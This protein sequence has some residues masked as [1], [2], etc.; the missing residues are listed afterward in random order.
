MDLAQ[1][2][3]RARIRASGR[4]TFAEFMALAL[5]GPGGYYTQGQ[6][7]GAAGDYYTSPK[8]H[9]AF[10]ALI[11]LQIEQMWRLL[12]SPATFHVAEAG[13]GDGTLATDIVGFASHLDPG[14]REALA[15]VA[16]DA[17][18]RPGAPLDPDPPP[19]LPPTPS[20]TGQGE[21]SPPRSA[22]LAPETKE[23]V[24]IV[25]TDRL[26]SVRWLKTA[27]FPLRDLIGCILSNEL[28]DAL[29]VHRVAVHGG[30]LV[31][32]YV[33][34]QGGSFTEVWDEP[35]TTRLAERLAG[36]RAELTGQGEGCPARNARPAPKTE[37]WEGEVALTAAAWMGAAAHSLRRGYALTIDYGDESDRLYTMERAKGTLTSYYRHAQQTNLYARPGRQDITAHANFT[38]LI[39]SGL[40]EGLRPVSL[41]TQGEFLRNLGIEAFLDHAAAAAAQGRADLTGLRGLIRPDGLGNFRV[42]I[43]AKNAPAADLACLGRDPSGTERLL[44]RLRSLPLPSLGHRHI[45]LLSGQ[46]PGSQGGWQEGRREDIL[47]RG[48]MTLLGT[49]PCSRTP[50]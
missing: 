34:L 24:G 17:H 15:Y 42:L 18:P 12:G 37:G 16:L 4:I 48:L 1:E 33:A 31:E 7:I 49:T 6:P 43:Q 28:V 45:H 40:P 41:M 19:H 32:A 14:F 38:T 35:S 25:A 9:P 27:D 36:D 11:A 50:T 8:A 5:Y 21:G 39:E 3:I 47:G 2:T 10:G 22:R 30:R 46:F 26:A 44:D 23:G 29:P 13:A 20:F